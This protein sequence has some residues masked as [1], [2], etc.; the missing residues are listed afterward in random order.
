MWKFCRTTGLIFGLFGF[1][2]V[3][4]VQLVDKSFLEIYFSLSGIISLV[5]WLSAGFFI[6]G[7]L[8][9]F[10]NRASTRKIK[11]LQDND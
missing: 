2:F 11:D 3:N 4:L 10:I 8:L 5:L 7:P 1:V 9:W 6:V